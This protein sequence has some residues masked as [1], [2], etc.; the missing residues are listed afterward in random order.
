MKSV[1]IPVLALLFTTMTAA[2]DFPKAEVFAGYT[3]VRANSALDNPS[4]SAN[5]GSG[6]LVVN[7]NRWVGFVTDIGA[8][9]NGNISDVHLDSTFTH[10]MFGPRISIRKHSRV[11]PFFQFLMGGVHAS[12]SKGLDVDIPPHAGNPIYIPGQGDVVQGGQVSLRAGH[13]QTAFG[14]G[15]GGGMDIKINKYVSFRPISLEWY[16]ARLQN[17]RTLTDNNQQ[18]LRYS[19]GFNFTLGGEE[20]SPPPPPQPQPAMKSCWDGTSVLATEDCPLR[21]LSLRLAGADKGLCSG[22]VLPIAPAGPLPD[23]AEY[24]WTLN[25]ESMGQG[26][27][28]EFGAIGRTPGPYEVGL[29]VKAP[30]FE[31]TSARATITVLP[32][33][34]P[35]GSLAVSPI[36]IWQGDEAA[37]D[38]NFAPGQCGGALGSPSFAASEGAVRGNRFDSSGVQFDPTDN[39]EQ[40]KTVTLSAKVSDER[41]SASAEATVVVKKRAAVMAKRLPDVVFPEDSARVNNCGARLLLEE[42]KSYASSD[43]GGRV[44]FVGHVS[45]K[46]TGNSGLDL[47]RALN[48][49]AMISAGTGICSSFPANRILVGVAGADDNGVDYQSHFCGTSTMPM[50]EERPGQTVQSSDGSAKYRRVEVWFIPSGGTLPASLKDPK[51]AET[52]SVASLGCPR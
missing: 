43:P 8:V 49:A 30:G 21:K 50:P 40:R 3:Y 4:F 26:Q 12:T 23:G 25:G 36:E 42:L 37:I 39:S 9:H 29:T 41:G 22:E 15:L 11:T 6:Q 7:F 14:F 16:M 44:V 28:L 32:Y 45:A 5:G 18:N 17:I 33:R 13:S 20:P 46:E 2:Q 35:S 19:T 1:T 51:D 52:L 34:P 10:Y 27:S 38:A 48:A 31:D 47:K 24:H